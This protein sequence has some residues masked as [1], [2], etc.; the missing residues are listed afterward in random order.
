LVDKFYGL[1]HFDRQDE[2]SRLFLA[3]CFSQFITQYVQTKISNALSR[4][5]ILFILSKLHKLGV[6]LAVQDQDAYAFMAI[7]QDNE[8]TIDNLLLFKQLSL[9]VANKIRTL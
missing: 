9:S 5:M 2:E 8:L 4:E 6:T 3:V 7:F 1:S